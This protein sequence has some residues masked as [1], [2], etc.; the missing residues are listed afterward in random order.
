M[1]AAFQSIFVISILVMP[2]MMWASFPIILIMLLPLGDTP[3]RTVQEGAILA[4]ILGG[5]VLLG[6]CTMNYE[7]MVP[8]IDTS[9][10]PPEKEKLAALAIKFEGMLNALNLWYMS[11]WTSNNRIAFGL[12]SALVTTF[13][14]SQATVVLN[15]TE[16]GLAKLG[17]IISTIVMVVILIIN[18]SLKKANV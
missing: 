4:G 6:V 14:L 2:V 18:S 1:L 7:F 8:H 12:F 5:P 13:A 10:F 3:L 15:V 11:Y 17:G 16:A 9:K